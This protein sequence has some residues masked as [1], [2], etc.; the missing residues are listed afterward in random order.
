MT[1]MNASRQAP[2]G[3]RSGSDDPGAGS[4]DPVTLIEQALVAMRRDQE[5]R[6][7]QRRAERNERADRDER[8]GHGERGERGRGGRG[9]W[10][11]GAR[12]RRGHDE[13]HGH[14]HSEWRG[15]HGD[16]HD[17]EPGH[18]HHPGSHRGAHLAHAARFRLLDALENADH[19]L[20]VSELADAIGV[21]QPRAS[22]LVQAAV[23]AGHARREADPGDARRSA[24]VLT[25]AGRAL[26]ASAHENRRGAIESALEGFT[27]QETAEFARLLSR[28]VEAWPRD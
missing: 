1:Y 24:I 27:P 12:G 10:P 11:G 13:Q 17:A 23:E 28:F 25:T 18:P 22:R 26:L 6:R 19:A 15:P 21:D 16:P 7:L 20:S 8:D 4:R 14:E 9:G 2:P 3:E 5:R